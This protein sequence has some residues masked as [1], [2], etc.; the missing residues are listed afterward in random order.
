MFNST[1]WIRHD[2]EASAR[3]HGNPMDCLRDRMFAMEHNLDTLR[4]RLTQVADLRDAQGIR[5]DHRDIIARLNEVEECATVHTLREFMSKICRLEAL[6]TGEDGGAIFGAIRACNQRIDSQKNALED[7]DARIRTQDWY[8]DISDQAEDEEMENQSAIENRASG[9]RRPRGHAPQRR[10]MQQWTRPTPRPPLPEG[11]AQAL[12]NERTSENVEEMQQAMQRLLAAYNQCT[13]R[14]TQTDDRMEQFRSNLRRDALDLALTVKRIEQDVQHQYQATARLKQKQSLQ[15][16]V[17]ERVKGLE[18]RLRVALEHETHVNQT[19]DRNAHTQCAS[20]AAIMELQRDV[21][22]LVED[23]ASRVDQWFDHSQGT[24]DAAQNELSTQALLETNDLRSKVARLTE[25]NTKLEGSVSYL[26]SL[27]EHVDALWKCLPPGTGEDG[28]ER[29]VSAAEGQD[30]MD[31]FRA[32]VYHKIKE[33]ATG[34]NNLRESVTL[35]EK[36]RDESWEAVSHRVSTMVESSVGSLTERLTE[37]EHTVQSQGTTPVTD[38]DVLDMKTWSTLEQVIWAELNKVK[39]TAQ[40]VPNIY[41]LCEGLQENQKSQEKQ[42]TVLR[43]FA[44][45]VERYLAQVK[46][47]AVAPKESM[48]TRK[49]RGES[50]ESLGYV[51]GAPASSSAGANPTRQS[52]TPPQ[53]P[54]THGPK[55]KGGHCPKKIT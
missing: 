45:Q 4:T 42:I 52:P 48:D 53:T 22:K 3:A 41:T 38:D 26:S 55:S 44:R 23:M 6:F 16:D 39:E 11:N 43:N 17:Q 9:R 32:D 49:T 27:Q 20:I 31:E 25:Q 7:I 29:V 50:N 34:L 2:P 14:D 24:S 35:I 36:D 40:E 15:N 10:T 1:I 37:L 33:L 5:A 51:P 30:E 54:T 46:S 18:E 28:P 47:G 12:E 8:H 19:I 13:T 21:R